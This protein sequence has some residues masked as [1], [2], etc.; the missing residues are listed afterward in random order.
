M[1][2]LVGEEDLIK[3]QKNIFV[4]YDV[5]L[6]GSMQKRNHCKIMC[7]STWEAL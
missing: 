5:M 4:Q 7:S 1:K 6:L 3:T 2:E